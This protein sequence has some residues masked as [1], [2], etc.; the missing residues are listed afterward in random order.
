MGVPSEPKRV[1]LFVST[2][3]K[4]KE[5]YFKAI[6][7]LEEIYGSIILESSPRLWTYSDYYNEEIGTPLFRRFIFFRDLISEEDIAEIK[8][9]TNQ[10]EKE[11]SIDGKRTIN[12][13]PGYIG[14]AKL[15]LATTKDYSHRIYLKKGIYGEVTLIY[16]GNSFTPHINTYKDYADKEYIELFNLARNIYKR[17]LYK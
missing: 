5:A 6:R 2:L 4:D 9:Q 12:L 14:L 15:V 3:F 16:R 11:L 13:D 7:V 1:L 10:I 8:T 17:L